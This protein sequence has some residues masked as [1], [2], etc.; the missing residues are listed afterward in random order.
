LPVVR[1]IF[2][3]ELFGIGSPENKKPPETG[4]FVFGKKL[5]LIAYRAER[6]CIFLRKPSIATNDTPKRTLVVAPSGTA[7]VLSPFWR[8]VETGFIQSMSGTCEPDTTRAAE[9]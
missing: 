9:G 2:R 4:G 3:T 1:R 5:F 7:G 8:S 6:I